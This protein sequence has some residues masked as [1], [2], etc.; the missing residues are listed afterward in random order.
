MYSISTRAN[1]VFFYGVV[2]IG[3][4]CSFNII[5][6]ILHKDPPIVNKFTINEFT[7][8]YQHPYTKV[9]HAS[10]NFT[11]EADFTPCF[12]WNTNLVFA[13]ISATYNTGKNNVY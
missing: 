2:M 5:T 13:W 4:L 9:Q 6:T 10:G 3:I 12:N 7:H 8:L 1:S 11:L